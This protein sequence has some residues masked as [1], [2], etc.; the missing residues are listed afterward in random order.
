MCNLYSFTKGQQAIRDITRAMID[1][2][3]NLPLFPGIFPDYSAPIVRN[4]AAGREVTL[5][6]WGRR[7]NECLYAF[8]TTEANAEVGAIHLNASALAMTKAQSAQ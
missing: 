8:L 6:R 4:S 2:T 3:G 5:A 1:K 7:D